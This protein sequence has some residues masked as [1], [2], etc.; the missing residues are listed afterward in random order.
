LANRLEQIL[1][2]QVVIY[3]MA[4][5]RKMIRMARSCG[6]TNNESIDGDEVAAVRPNQDKNMAG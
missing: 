1:S 5:S 2:P 4:L 3:A 6:R